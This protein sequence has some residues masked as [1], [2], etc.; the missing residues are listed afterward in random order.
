MSEQLKL[1]GGAICTACGPVGS[2]AYNSCNNQVAQG[3]IPSCAA[4]KGGTLAPTQAGAPAISTAYVSSSSQAV[5][6][7][8]SAPPAVTGPTFWVQLGQRIGL[9][10]VALTLFIMGL[11]LLFSKEVTQAA[12]TAASIATKAA[13]VGA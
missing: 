7:Y 3:I 12:H 8:N 11:F 9:L 4:P 2:A 1:P 5:F 13:I 6:G 10:A